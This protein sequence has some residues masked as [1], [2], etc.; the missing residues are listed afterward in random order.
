MYQR[1]TRIGPLSFG[2][3]YGLATAIMFLI[4]GLIGLAFGPGMMMIPPEMAAEGMGRGMMMGG[5][6]IVGVLLGV[7]MGFVVGL[8][9]GILGAVI[10]NLVASVTGG[11]KVQFDEMYGDDF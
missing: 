7:L 1:L 6:G 9:F 4:F 2:L 3:L 10:Y 5:G 11:V 8:I